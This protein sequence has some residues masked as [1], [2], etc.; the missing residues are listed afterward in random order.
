IVGIRIPS[1]EAC[2]SIVKR[3][4]RPI[5]STSANPSGARSA[6]SDKSI[7]RA[8]RGKVSLVIKGRCPHGKES[9]IIEMSQ[10]KI[11]RKGARW[12]DV[13]RILKD[14]SQG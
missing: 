3:F 1:S 12:K 11:V 5:T 2:L 7:A 13:E 14:F 4:G 6:K 8:I 10:A 9:T